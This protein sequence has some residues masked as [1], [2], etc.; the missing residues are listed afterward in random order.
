M[1]HR[2]PDRE[3]DTAAHKLA[4]M[5]ELAVHMRQPANSG[6]SMV[7]LQMLRSRRARRRAEE[8]RARVDPGGMEADEVVARTAEEQRAEPAAE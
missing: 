7:P 1:G 5:S 6:S 2:T 4:D 3:V 8:I